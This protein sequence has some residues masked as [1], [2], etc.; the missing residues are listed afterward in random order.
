MSSR[1]RR[2]WSEWKEHVTGMH[3]LDSGFNQ[4][5][6]S[7]G[8][9]QATR[10]AVSLRDLDLEKTSSAT[11]PWVW[12]LVFLGLLVVRKVYFEHTKFERLRN[13]ASVERIR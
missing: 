11:R 2:D 8:S 5:H 4:R 7:S 6:V 12:V 9:H 10:T 3:R 13:P 1:K